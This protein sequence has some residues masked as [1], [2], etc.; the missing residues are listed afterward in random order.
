MD[1]WWPLQFDSN[2]DQANSEYEKVTEWLDK[3]GF[4]N[5]HL[6]SPHPAYKRRAKR[7]V[8]LEE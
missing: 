6:G 8:E 5:P 7:R 1:N 4:F 2:F 3:V